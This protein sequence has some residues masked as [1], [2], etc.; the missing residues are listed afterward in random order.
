[1][2]TNIDKKEDECCAK[3]K[4]QKKRCKETTPTNEEM[5]AR[6]YEHISHSY[7]AESLLRRMRGL[8]R[9]ADTAS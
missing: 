6:E 8:H 9:M 4:R 1:M 7:S 3:H 2:V 5:V